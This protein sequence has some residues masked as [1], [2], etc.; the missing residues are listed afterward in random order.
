AGHT[1]HHDPYRFPRGAVSAGR[2]V[3]AHLLVLLLLFHGF[4]WSLLRGPRA[5]GSQSA[6]SRAVFWPKYCRDASCSSCQ[7]RSA[8]WADHSLG[9]ASEIYA[10]FPGAGYFEVSWDCQGG[11][12]TADLTGLDTCL[13]PHHPRGYFAALFQY[14]NVSGA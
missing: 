6:D 3:S 10:F 4:H 12:Q 14:S 7:V 5:V 8:S 1:P 13:L 11:Q 9:Q 2:G